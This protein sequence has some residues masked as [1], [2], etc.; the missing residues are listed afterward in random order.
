MGMNRPARS[1]RGVAQVII[2]DDVTHDEQRLPTH[3]HD[4][5]P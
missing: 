3:A 5:I 2:W 4:L 1:Q